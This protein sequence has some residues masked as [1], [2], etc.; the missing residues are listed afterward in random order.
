MKKVKFI[1]NPYSGNKAIL[2][3]IDTIIDIYQTKGYTIIPYRIER[4][5]DV[6]SAFE[7]GNISEYA[8]ILIAGGDGTVDSVVNAMYKKNIDLPIGILPVGT[9]NDFAKFLKIP[10]SIEGACQLILN[11]S[12]TDID[13]AKINDK[14][15]V[16]VASTG[17]FADV[18]QKTDINLKN[19]MGKLAYCIK[20]LEELPNFRKI[21]MSLKSDEANFDGDVYLLLIFNGKT[22]GN[23]TLAVDS[24]AQDGLLDVVVFKAI[25][26]REMIPLFISVLKGEHLESDKVLYFKTNKIYIECDE[27]IETDIDGEAG[28]AFP[29][30]IECIKSGLKILGIK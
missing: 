22:A 2:D 1:Y 3:K 24:D 10:S 9:A 20:G 7:D 13:L 28:P 4:Q 29:L 11:T 16:N 5:K 18:S 8:H 30:S 21:K 27:N 15:F 6:I 19:T 26:V 17:L 25:P 14:Y 23:F 12:P